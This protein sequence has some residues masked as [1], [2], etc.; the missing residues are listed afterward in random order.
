[1]PSPPVL[2]LLMKCSILS[3]FCVTGVTFDP[4]FPFTSSTDKNR[5]G[6]SHVQE[7]DEWEVGLPHKGGKTDQ[8]K[9]VSPGK[10]FMVQIFVQKSVAV[11]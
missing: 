1:M 8:R 3:L 5:H 4:M 6:S 10:C 11:V 7:A 9:G 2:T